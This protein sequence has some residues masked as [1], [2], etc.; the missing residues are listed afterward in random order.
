[1]FRQHRAGLRH[2]GHLHHTRSDSL[3]S[4]S[5]LNQ[6]GHWITALY[7]NLGKTHPTSPASTAAS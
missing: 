5:P 4:L 6:L 7:L 2:S 3:P 1:M